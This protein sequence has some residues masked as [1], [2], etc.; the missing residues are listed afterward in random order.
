M[1]NELKVKAM[2]VSSERHWGISVLAVLGYIGAALTLLAGLAMI[3]GSAAIASLLAG[4]S[5]YEIFSTLGAMFIIIM[6]VIFLPLAVLYFFVARG[7]WNGKNW[8]RIVTLVFAGLGV[9]NSLFALP[10]S[11]INLALNGL[12][13]WYLGFYKPAVAYFK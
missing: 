1:K 4:V 2:P 13:I 5:G 7:L 8:A 3:F 9:L 11:I 10:V 12:I 6:G